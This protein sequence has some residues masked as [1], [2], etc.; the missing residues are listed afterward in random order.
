MT[1]VLNVDYESAECAE[2]FTRSLRETGF[3]VLTHHPV[4]AS[5]VRRVYGDWESFFASKGKFDYLFDKDKQDGYFPFLSENAKGYSVKDLKE[6]Y[7]VYPWGKYPTEISDQTRVLYD[8]LVTLA[9]KLLEWVEEHTPRDVKK[10]FSMPL[11]EMIDDSSRNLL[12]VIHYPPLTGEE[13]EGAIRAAPHED[14]NLLTLLVA[15]TEPG[16]QVQ[17]VEGNW[18]D[19]SCDYGTVAVNTGDMLQMCSGGFYPSTTHRVVNPPSGGANRSRYSMPM[20]LHARDEVWLS[21][22][23]TAGTYLQERLKEIGLKP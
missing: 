15:G 18:H 20:F 17:D 11:T 5:L 23:H 9:G 19:V 14:I 4:E 10:G 13:E 21:D 3:A 12:R 8:K 6:F 1:G 22:T 7:H 2:V 16:L